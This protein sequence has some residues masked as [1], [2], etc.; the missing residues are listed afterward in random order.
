MS[1]Q[2]NTVSLDSSIR[3]H[4]TRAMKPLLLTAAR[5][6]LAVLTFVLPLACAPSSAQT[7]QAGPPPAPAVGVEAAS[8][9]KLVDHAELTGR[10]GP[11]EM[12]EVRPRV[13]G[14]IREV[15]FEAG[16]IV[17][18]NQVLFRIDAR[19]NTAEVERREADLAA[20]RTRLEIAEK[21]G[22]RA[23][24]LIDSRAI[25]KEELESRASR[26]QEARADEASR[27]ADLTS[28]RLDLE[29]TEIKAPI[30]GRISR[31]LVTEGNYVSGVAG[32]NTVLATIVSVDPVYFYADLDEASYLRFEAHA[33]SAQ[34]ANQPIQVELGLS[35]EEGY[36][37]VGK[38]ESI[39]N[40]LDPASGTILLRATVPNA[41][42]RLV[43]GLFARARIPLG[44][45][46]SQVVIDDRAV[47]TDQNQKFVLVVGEGD[48]AEYRRVKLG[49]VHEGRRVVREGLKDGER[50]IVTGLQKVRPGMPVKP[51]PVAPAANDTGAQR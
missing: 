14:H 18:E 2:P 17:E 31:A 25:S 44:A 45:P 20:A 6:L 13:S 22:E 4:S 35:D 15:L 43:P 38:L 40:Q 5:P 37:R 49:P 11:V 8:T 46:E 26:V 48:V 9:V 32:T 19:W 3:S 27:R 39:D 7:E 33:R 28:A 30:R 42:G 24:K 1:T 47:G 34:K 29:Y 23:S 10:L 51:E 12:V 41:D 16:Q 50:I 36:P 21:E